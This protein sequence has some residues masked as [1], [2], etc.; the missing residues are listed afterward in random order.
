[1]SAYSATQHGVIYMVSSTEKIVVANWKMFFNYNETV[2][3]ITTYKQE[4]E[5]LVLL[6]QSKLVVCPS[7]VA[8]SVSRLLLNNALI[9]L[10]A[11]DCSAYTSGPFTGDASLLRATGRPSPLSSAQQ[12]L[13]FLEQL[14]LSRHAYNL[15]EAIRLRGPLQVEAL[16]QSL[17]EIVRRHEVLR[18]TFI[19]SAGQPLQVIG[20]A[21][22]VPVAVVDLRE[23]SP[24]EQEGKVY[25]L[26]Q[27]ESSARLI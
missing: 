24:R 13:W 22:H 15:L 26:A 2:A 7:F 16:G 27:A 1:M 23:L 18:T 20:P 9:K 12:R 8:L 3:W 17:Q 25:T 19:N 14:G 21:T 4:L 6:S 11:Q 5:Q 10:G